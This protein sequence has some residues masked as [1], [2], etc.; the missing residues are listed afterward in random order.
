MRK[1]R[2]YKKKMGGGGGGGGGGEEGSFVNCR[3]CQKNS[4]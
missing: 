1:Y 4:C 2:I 3:C